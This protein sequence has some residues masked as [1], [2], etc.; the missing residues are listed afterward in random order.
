[1]FVEL[2]LHGRGGQ[3]IVTASEMLVEAAT[4]EGC[5][6]QSI[7]YY[8]AERR[9]APVT[10]FARISDSPI[11]RHAQVYNPDVVAIFDHQFLCRPEVTLGLKDNGSIV[12]NAKQM[13][14][15][16]KFKF[17]VVDATRI[18]MENGLVVAGWAVVNTAMLGAIARVLGGIS[19]EAVEKV[20]RMRWSGDLGDRNIK[21]ALH[22]FEEVSGWGRK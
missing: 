3:G 15:A 1:L 14:D 10:A 12:V 13:P 20:V 9:G 18:A 11:R 5:Y 7:P 2:R 19:K 4:M 16:Q 22:A 6:G 8:G 17:Y 21:A